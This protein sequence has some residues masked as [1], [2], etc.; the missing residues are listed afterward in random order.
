MGIKDFSFICAKTPLPLCSVVKSTKHLVLSNSTS[1]YDFN[2][3]HL[4][5]GILPSCYAR[6]VEI[7]NTMIFDVGNAF[8]NI[9]ALGTIL[10][11]IFNVRQKYT[12]IGRSEYLYFFH[13]LILLI[14]FT[15][16]VDCVMVPPGQGIYRYLVAIQIG[17][18][19]S[20]C[21]S[22]FIN[23]LLPFNFWEDGTR[24]SMNITR[25]ASLLGF[26]A[27]FLVSIFTF[28]SWI[29]SN[30]EYE[31][32]ATAMVVVVYV[33]NAVL[34]FLY[35][36]C[37]LLVSVVMLR[38]LWITGSVLLGVVFF[39]V[40]QILTY[41]FSTQICEGV[42]HYLDGLFFGSICNT[43]TFMMI[44][45]TWDMSTDD[46]LEFSVNVNNKDDTVYLYK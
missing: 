13:L 15:L 35:T 25:V 41:G 20:C 16:I 28:R 46:D 44:Y 19:G 8:V 9:G 4:Q 30:A 38:N 29:N 26:S 45:K 11:I 21:W 12:A 31:L 10:I 24:K 23:G 36:V 34:L 40:G 14:L 27:N 3:Q 2:P 6:S 33:F 17:F 22:L 39:A 18:A 43:F 32:D 5:V 42:N 1:I 37:Q 7:S